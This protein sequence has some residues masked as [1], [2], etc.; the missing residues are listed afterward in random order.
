MRSIPSTEWRKTRIVLLILALFLGGSSETLCT[1]GEVVG[2]E[3][4]LL[5]EPAPGRALVYIAQMASTETRVFVDK[6]PVASLPRKSYV[7][8]SME[9]GKRLIWTRPGY[10]RQ[11]QKIWAA[12]FELEPGR[13]Y[14]LW[15]P[16]LYLDSPEKVPSL[17]A[18]LHY[19]TPGEMDL[20]QLSCIAKQP[21]RF[22]IAVELAGDFESVA[23]PREFEEIKHI[24]KSPHK[25]KRGYTTV[26]AGRLAVTEDEL[27]YRSEGQTIIIPVIEIQSATLGGF[28]VR[29]GARA[30][31]PIL[32]LRYGRPE[33]PR[34]VLFEVRVDSA[35]GAPSRWNLLFAT[36]SEASEICRSSAR[37][38]LHRVADL[39][40]G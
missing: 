33:A 37:L 7:A 1:A 20:E 38:E 18:D 2:S 16:Y 28:R 15:L 24:E 3:A 6:T 5:P 31:T 40:D 23:L 12:W 8:V 11:V 27:T 35:P 17:V 22:N 32:H 36:L 13:S 34:D 14:L 10:T 21:E 9:P 30:S 29:Y 39:G 4:A 26:S 25:L 19:A